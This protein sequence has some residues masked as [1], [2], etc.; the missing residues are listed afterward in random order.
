MD[1]VAAL[2]AAGIVL[3]GGRSSRMG[4]PK[5]GLEWHGSTL[6]HRTAAVL[7]RGVSGPVVVVRAAGQDLPPLPD[8]VRV[9]DD[10]VAGLGPLQGIGAGLA[11]VEDEAG[12]AFVCSTDL[13]FLHPAFVHRVLACIGDGDV[14]LPVAHGFRQPLAAVYR[15][16]LASPIAALLDAGRRRPG[17]LFEQCR[18][19]VLDEATLLADPV[20]ARLDPALDSLINVNEP[21]DYAAARARPAPWVRVRRDT[22][23]TTGPSNEGRDTDGVRAATVGRAAE[24]VGLSRRTRAM[25]NGAP[26]GSDPDV[27]LVPGDTVT[28]LPADA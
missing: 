21:A 5:A 19:T 13:P 17:M 18:V 23:E 4:R 9:I 14:A 8:G 3:A 22:G 11:A 2:G 20:L 26:P 7:R 28:F 10:P 16:G 24:A 12:A 15:T 25:V 6:L 27:A 1:G